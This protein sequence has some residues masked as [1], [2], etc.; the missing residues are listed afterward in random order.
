MTEQE[1]MLT[2]LLDCRRIDLFVD[3]PELSDEQT[4][5]LLDMETRR[6]NGEPLQY[7]LGQSE[8][9][10]LTF[11][12]NQWVLIPRPETELLVEAAIAKAKQFKSQNLRF[13]DIGT[14]SGNIAISLAKNIPGCEVTSVDISS[15]ALDVAISN[16]I[17]QGVADRTKFLRSD[18]FEALRMFSNGNQK[19]DVIVS[20]PPY[21]PTHQL[22]DLPLD[23]QKEPKLA[24]DG[25]EDGLGFYRRIIPESVAYLKK[26]G[27]LILE[28]GED[29]R[30]TVEDIFLGVHQFGNIH[31]L[32]DYANKDRILTAELT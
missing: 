4:R 19:F 8:F 2:H 28:I 24:L 18:L 16:A 23:V 6:T 27:F 1:L 20:N 7:I 11:L 29:Q 17:R 13:L 25:G 30:R 3:P 15:L 22:L 31:C 26:G 12:V 21:V 9:I 5:Q 32:K 10:G 14:G